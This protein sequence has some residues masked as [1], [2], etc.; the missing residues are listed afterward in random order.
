MLILVNCLGSLAAPALKRWIYLQLQVYFKMG[1]AVVANHALSCHRVTPVS[2]GIAEI[3]STSN[4]KRA[5]FQSTGLLA[6][7]RRER[8]TSRHHIL[9][10]RKTSWS[11]AAAGHEL[12]ETSTSIDVE[13]IEAEAPTLLALSSD[14]D[15][16]R[17]VTELREEARGALS[18][19]SEKALILE[20]LGA[21][22]DGWLHERMFQSVLQPSL[23]QGVQ[24]PQ[25][26]L[27]FRIR[28]E[29]LRWQAAL[30]V[31]KSFHTQIT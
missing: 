6:L 2:Y 19:E 1:S 28:V 27:G 10:R 17:S 24:D 29:E 21:V 26:E 30:Q 5:L 11:A 8:P 4:S 18:A 31:D 22:M 16:Q 14:L 7:P 12:L 15:W 9:R 3:P 13:G 20:R 25:E 23:N